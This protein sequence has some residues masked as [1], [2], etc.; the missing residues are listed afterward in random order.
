[1]IE[2]TLVLTILA[3][4]F[5]AWYAWIT[6]SALTLYIFFT[7]RVTEWRTQYRRQANEFDSAAHTKAIDSL[8]NYETVKYFGNEAFEASR[9]DESLERLRRARLKAQ[10]S[11]SLLNAGQQLII[12]IALVAMLWRATQGVVEG[13]MTLGD[14]VM[15][16]A[17]MIQLYIPLG[18]LGVLYREIKQ[19]LTDLDKMF[20]LLETNREV[21]DVPGAQPLHL[22][23][24][25]VSVQFDHVSFGYERGD[26]ERIA[27]LLQATQAQDPQIVRERGLGPEH[28]IQI[29]PHRAALRSFAPVVVPAG[30]Y[31]M[32]GDNRDNSGDSRYFG[33][34]P[35]R[36]IVGLASRVVVSFDPE[37]YYR[38]R[39]DRF[40]T[41]LG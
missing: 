28:D 40:L 7:V 27:S 35:R 4:R 30:A 32:M 36:N 8:L 15:I 10:T 21:A 22:D 14:L 6:L 38:P 25:A 3:V 9:Y 26:A 19:S 12:A 11:L 2:V 20:T 34:V 16:N 17:F 1:L 18:F 23:E 39:G 31:F 33:F 13:R 41:P 24:A 29:L 5:D 37:H